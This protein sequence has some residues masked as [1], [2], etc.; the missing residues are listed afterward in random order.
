MKRITKKEAFEDLATLLAIFSCRGD[1][2]ELEC[3]TF[4]NLTRYI[5]QQYDFEESEGKQNGND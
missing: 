5:E 3:E 2:Q 1:L 4:I